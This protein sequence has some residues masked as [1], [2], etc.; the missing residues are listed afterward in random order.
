M[1]RKYSIENLHLRE[2]KV[3]GEL[4]LYIVEESENVSNDISWT[5]KYCELKDVNVKK[6]ND[7]IEYTLKIIPSGLGSKF[8]YRKFNDKEQ[9]GIMYSLSSVLKQL[10]GMS[11]SEIENKRYTKKELQKLINDINA[12]KKHAK[13]DEM[14]LV[15]YNEQYKGARILEGKHIAKSRDGSEVICVEDESVKVMV[16]R[17]A[18]G[19]KMIVKQVGEDGK[20]KRRE[21][22]ILSKDYTLSYFKLPNLYSGKNERMPRMDTRSI[23]SNFRSH[24]KC[25][26]SKY[27]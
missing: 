12:R 18:R 10:F 4:K 8:I 20:V 2:D 11:Q 1:G 5:I 16:K 17:S 22:I 23:K 7:I 26:I 24:K 13:Y 9:F 15:S 21:T 27:I 19:E 6:K 3:T 14:Y 25:Y